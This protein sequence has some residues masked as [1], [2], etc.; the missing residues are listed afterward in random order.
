MKK[1]GNIGNI[2]ITVEYEDED[3]CLIL[4]NRDEKAES[5]SIYY[6]ESH[7][8]AIEKP[9]EKEFELPGYGQQ[10]VSLPAEFEKWSELYFHVGKENRIIS[11]PSLK[12]LSTETKRWAKADP[13][14]PKTE[15]S[16]PKSEQ[17]AN[18]RNTIDKP[19]KPEIETLNVPKR[20]TVDYQRKAEI[21]IQEAQAEVESLTR[22][23]E[24]GEPVDIIE[25]EDPTPSQ[26]ALTILNWMVRTIEDWKDELEQSGTATPDLVQTLEFANQDIKEKLKEIRGSAPPLL[27][28]PNL[29]TEVS[30]DV[31]YNEFKNKCAAY[32]SRYKRFVIDYQLGR[33]I[34]ETEYNQFIPQFI[35][36]RLFNGIA[37]F[38][39]V[40]QFPDRLDQCLQLVGYEVV[41]IEIGETLADA[42]LHDIQASQQTGV[43]PGT[44]VEVVLPGLQRKTDGEI[45]QKPVVI[46]GE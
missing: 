40:E 44:I 6:K 14:Q 39:S 13:L 32:V 26:R 11:N 15:P 5:I 33:Q 7:N 22:A 8:T 46:R 4:D 23:Y 41:P 42:R 12:K 45:V 27:E 10:E 31:A 38:H 17:T 35:K 37:R 16:N 36:D 43:A 34:D 9:L 28:P 30:T 25:I 2:F 24:D 19:P 1:I 20:R 29:D 21:N 3:V 18:S